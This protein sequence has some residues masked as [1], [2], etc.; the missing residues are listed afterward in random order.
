MMPG[1][2]IGEKMNNQLDSQTTKLIEEYFDAF[3][4]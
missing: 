3:S 2:A 1:W 4:H